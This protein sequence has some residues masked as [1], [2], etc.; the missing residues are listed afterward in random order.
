MR[1]LTLLALA[2]LATGA[3]AQTTFTETEPNDSKATAN[4]F[5]LAPGDKITGTTTG[6]STTTPGITSA[7]YFRLSFGATTPGV[8]FNQL[9]INPVASGAF[10]GTI[11]GYFQN[12]AGPVG[13]ID[14]ASEAPAQV[15]AI[16][17]TTNDR[18]N[19]FYS[20]GNAYSINYKIT[21]S[22]TTTGNYTATYTRTAVTPIN[23]GTLTGNNIRISTFGGFTD[24]D[25]ALYD[26]NYNVI[27]TN[28]DDPTYSNASGT[29]LI[30]QTLAAGTYTLAISNY[31][32]ATDQASPPSDAFRGGIVV[33]GPG[34]VLNSSST[35]SISAPLNIT[36]E[37]GGTLSTTWSRNQKYGVG[38]YTFTVANPVPEPATMAVLGLGALGLLRRRRRS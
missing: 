24:T 7:D 22:S 15:S 6:S 5:T 23:L 1:T 35:Q 18:I 33:D 31:N 8:Y 25:L 38:F 29:S 26:S 10:I 30:V 19:R 3:F 37:L 27:T 16:A 20:F 14:T 17:E 12:G 9:S 32:L 13:V 4:A 11:L 21:G 28:D 2:G 36:D 34:F